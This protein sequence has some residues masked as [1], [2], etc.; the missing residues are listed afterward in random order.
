M[1]RKHGALK[2]LGEQ[3]TAGL[4]R[5]YFHGKPYLVHKDVALNQVVE[6][7]QNELPVKE[8]DYFT[9]ASLDFLVCRDDEQFS[10]E[11]AIEYDGAQHEQPE[12]A[13]KDEA[14]NRICRDSDL[15]FLRIGDD[16]V[17]LRRDISILDFIL[18]QYFGEKAVSAL[19]EAGKLGREEEYFADFAPTIELKQRL[20]KRGLFPPVFAFDPAYRLYWYQV[21]GQKL[22][23]PNSSRPGP[24]SWKATTQINIYKGPSTDAMVFHV[25]RSASIRD[26]NPSYSA[27]GVHGWHVASEL[28]TYLCF[29]YIEKEWL[30]EQSSHRTN[31]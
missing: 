30:P 25:R 2:S 8:F 11:L 14:K 22:D 16:A 4:L 10:Y 24:Q 20:M 1:R 26:P 15:P 13:W 12:Q 18:D 29:D 6:L 27:E 19:R 17:T 9:R 28:A 23:H 5:R 21:L 31:G 3:S 7:Q